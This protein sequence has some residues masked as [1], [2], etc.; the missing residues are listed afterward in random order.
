M[1]SFVFNIA[2]GRVRTLAE[3]GAANDALIAVPVE[4]SGVQSDATLVDMDDLAAVFAGATNEQTTMGRKTLT[5]VTVT[6]DDTNDRLALD[7]DDIVWSGATGNPISD[8]IIAYDGDTTGGTDA[9]IV[10]VSM[11]DFAA[12]PDGLD[13]TATVTDFIRSA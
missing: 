7:C 5:N 9:N 4:A 12:T 8:I 10:P 13:I 2:K 6:V 1:A 3:L 11:H